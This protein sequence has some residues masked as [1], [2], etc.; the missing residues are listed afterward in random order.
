MGN[1]GG[2][3]SQRWGCAFLSSALGLPIRDRTDGYQG[4]WEV[5]SLQQPVF[6]AHN[7]L[8]W[9]PR[10]SPWLASAHLP[11]CELEPAFPT[12]AQCR[13]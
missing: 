12:L 6:R 11:H 10:A 4:P 8:Q 13:A 3:G 2:I 1:V 7:Q 5:G 9:W